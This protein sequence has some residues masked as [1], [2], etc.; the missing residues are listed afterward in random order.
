MESRRIH[1]VIIS[2][3]LNKTG[4]EESIAPYYYRIK[5]PFKLFIV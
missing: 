3:S 5:N 1:E 2:L 4:G